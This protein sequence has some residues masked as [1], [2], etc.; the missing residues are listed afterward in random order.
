MHTG[1]YYTHVH[2]KPFLLFTIQGNKNSDLMKLNYMFLG[3]FCTE[4]VTQ[5]I[6][7]L[8]MYLGNRVLH[9]ILQ[10]VHM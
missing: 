9:Y 6:Q 2:L 5:D 1:R 3:S 8:Y 4:V 10:T 7:V